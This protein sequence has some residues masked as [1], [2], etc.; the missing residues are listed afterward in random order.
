MSKNFIVAIANSTLNAAEGHSSNSADVNRLRPY[1]ERALTLTGWDLDRIAPTRIGPGLPWNYERRARELL[2]QAQSVLDLGTGGGEL[3]AEL[4]A[5]YHGRAIASE[6]WA[7]NAP[8]AKRRLSR[9]EVDVV[10]AHSLRLPFH[11]GAFDLVLDRHEELDPNEVHRVLRRGGSLL[12]QQ[13]GENEWIELRPFFP[14]MQDFGPL[15]DR[16]VSGL[17]QTGMTV[18]VAK[19]H[20]FR[21]AYRGLGELVYLLCISPWTIPDFDPLGKDL[22]ALL[23]MEDRLA[24]REGLILT[25]SRFIIEARKTT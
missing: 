18:A 24:A 3:F 22:A 19:A 5:G 23:H 17:Q 4:C 15:L 11:S 14:R 6:P 13:I 10:R 12:T 20:D 1:V 8:L 2:A 21:S 9:L 7:V 16:Y 25:E